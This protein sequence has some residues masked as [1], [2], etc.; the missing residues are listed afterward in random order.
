MYFMANK[1]FLHYLDDLV[2]TL[3]IPIPSNL[4]KQ[5]YTLPISLESDDFD[6]DVLTVPKTLRELVAKYQQKRGK[7]NKQ[8]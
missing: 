7:F 4:T 3:E 5:E 1:A 2:E 8:E 6:K